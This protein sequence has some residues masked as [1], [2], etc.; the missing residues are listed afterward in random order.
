MLWETDEL[1]KDSVLSYTQEE[2]ILEQ[3]LLPYDLLGTAA[4]AKM[5]ESQGYLEKGELEEVM[6][7]LSEM[8]DEQHEI[9][10]E[11]VHTF[12][13]EKVTEYTDAGKK[14]HTGRSRNDQ[15]VIATRLLMKDS[16]IEIS[17]E[18]LELV[19]ELGEFAENE[20]QP[21]PGYTHQQ[22]AMPS[23]TG[24]WA[25]SYV[26]A[27]VDDLKLLQSA[28][29]VIDQ[30][31]LGAAAG[32]G[33]VLDIDRDKTTKLLGF[34]S[35]QENPI[36]CV[37]RGKHELMLLQALNH[38]MLDVQKLSEDL[39]NFSEDQ[40]FFDIPKEFCTGSSIM[41]QKKNPDVLE[42]ARA[43]A[44][45]VASHE[46]AIRS[47]IGKLPHGYNRDTQQTKKPLVE[48]IGTTLATL[49]ILADLVAELEVSDSFEIHDDIHAADTANKMVEDDLS[50]REAY[51]EVKQKQEYCSGD[52]IKEPVHQQYVELEKFW[53][54]EKSSFER[55]KESLLDS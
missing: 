9:E 25:S 3:K 48:S 34:K 28:Y 32:Y 7:K 42:I 53:K 4:H 29:E 37:N 18:L 30:N 14:I 49:E 5:L 31:P 13:E 36:Y 17:L 38:V 45:E 12:I 21:I 46:H 41:P 47:I 43:K 16:C 24:L 1:V 33:T 52:S 19:K 15:V 39:I 22:Q 23:S 27:L 2:T 40:K 51:Q 8:Y 50:F 20:N 44:D 10:G 35:K 54:A 11:D 6:E 55:T 26:D